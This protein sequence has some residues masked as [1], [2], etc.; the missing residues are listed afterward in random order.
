MILVPEQIV[1]F[2]SFTRLFSFMVVTTCLNGV[3]RY[4]AFEIGEKGRDMTQSYDKSPYTHKKPQKQRGNTQT[5]PKTSITHRLRTYLGRFWINNLLSTLVQLLHY[6][7]KYN[8]FGMTTFSLFLSKLLASLM[9]NYFPKRTSGTAL[10]TLSKLYDV[11]VGFV[12]PS[13]F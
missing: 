6:I 2:W 1:R 10:H 3:F 8:Y 7:L 13:L 9:R 12:T 5:Q 4:I 11:P